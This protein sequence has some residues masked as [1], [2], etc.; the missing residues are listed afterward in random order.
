[1]G[2]ETAD[3]AAMP[4][5]RIRMADVARALGVS[6][7]TVSRA[8]RGDVRISPARR[9]AVL[10]AAGRLGYQPHPL[11]QALM[12]QRRTGRAA[13]G[14]VL[15]LI[16]DYPGEA[17][18]RKDVCRWY[19]QG[20]EERAR[21]L[22]Y[23]L[24]VLSLADYQNDAARLRAV[25][26]ARGVHGAILG[27]ALEAPGTPLPAVDGLCVVGLS[28]YFRGLATD[29]VHLHGFYNVKLA[30]SRLRQAGYRRPALVAPVRN[31]AVVGGQWSAAALEEQWQ[32]PPE[33]QCP[34]FLVPAT[35][36]KM[37]EFQHWFEEHR[38]DALLA[39]KVRVDELLE[40]L[41][42]SGKVGIAY[43]FGTEEER[44]GQAGIDGNLD[45][46]GAAAVD[47]LVQKLQ[48]NEAGLP[49]FPRDVFIAGTWRD[50]PGGL[51]A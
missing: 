17:W 4:E 11:V 26:D 32:R 37:A 15:A 36:L 45:R 35:G 2:T 3:A 33:E 50:G 13:A 47:L 48:L 20:M 34:P 21:Q 41:R 38:P 28:T 40:R 31:N 19:W 7:A 43:L 23:Q 9:T 10:E 25:L 6:A 39:Y 30:L 24:E 18:R 49:Q 14:E 8:L 5:Q 27:F 22:G 16:T 46:V 29:R 12:T 42:E 44:A 51:P 1:M